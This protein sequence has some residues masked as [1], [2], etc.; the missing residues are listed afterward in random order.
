MFQEELDVLGGAFDCPVNRGAWSIEVLKLAMRN[1][2]EWFLHK[3]PLDALI[4]D[5]CYACK[6][7]RRDAP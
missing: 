1:N 6:F 3:E 4:K 5:I 7:N 2:A